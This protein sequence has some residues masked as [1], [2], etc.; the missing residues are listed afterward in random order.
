MIPHPEAWV[1]NLDE[2]PDRLAVF[3]ARAAAAG[4]SPTELIVPRTTTKRDGWG[5]SAE[6][7]G[8]A[9]AHFGILTAGTTPLT[10]F[11]DDAMIPPDLSKWIG[12]ALAALPRSWEMC[13]LGAG[14][15]ITDP[16]GVPPGRNLVPIRK[17]TLTHAYMVSTQGR[18]HLAECAQ[19][20]NWHWDH[21]ASRRMCG[22]GQV[23]GYV[24]PLVDQ[25]PALGSD[26]P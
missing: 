22:R 13:L 26:I 14:G 15:I 19:R 21:A 17:F 8:N 6:A 20:A 10:V 24:P 23:Y 4:I 7:C 1:I 2:R 18:P 3:R 9:M 16:P 12:L 5:G 11:E 25:D